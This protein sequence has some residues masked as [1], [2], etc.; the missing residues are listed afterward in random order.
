MKKQVDKGRLDSLKFDTS[1]VDSSGRLFSQRLNI[2]DQDTILNKAESICLNKLDI[3]ALKDYYIGQKINYHKDY[4]SGLEAPAVFFGKSIDYRES[5]K[6][7]DIKYIW[8][9]NRHLF[10]VTLALA[11]RIANTRKYLRK[12]EGYLADWLE[13]NKF[14]RGVNWTSSLEHGIRLINWTFCWHLLEK[15]VDSGLK[16]KWL[17]S[18][19]QHCWFISNNMSAFSSANNHLIGEAA[20]LYVASTALPKFK[21]SSM[22]QKKAYKILISECDKQNYPDGV[23]KE[24]AISYQ[25]FVLDFLLIAALVGKANGNPFPQK[26]LLRLE[27]MIE[28]LAALEDCEG[29][30]PQLG[31]EDD[32]FVID[33]GQREQGVYSSLINSGA[34]L[35]NR[36][37]F[38]KAGRPM[39]DKTSTL[40]NI[41][42]INIEAQPQREWSIPLSFDG[43][44]YYILGAHFGERREQKLVFDCGPLGYL[45]L[46]A[47]GHADALSFCFSAGGCPIFIDPGTY[48]YHA[49]TKWRNYFR[50]TVAH[51]TVCIDSADQSIIAGNFMWSKKAKAS[52]L[53]YEEGIRVKGTHDGY[54]RLHDSVKHTREIIF[55]K[56]SGIW[57]IID[58]IECEEDHKVAL[59][60]HLHPQCKLQILGN[61]A[62]IYFNK[63]SC[64]L[65]FPEDLTLLVY[66]GEEDPALGWYSPSYD[67]KLKT[68]TLKLTKRI[69]GSK[70]IITKFKVR[71]N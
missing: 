47:H 62:E 51:N 55:N 38:I 18:I 4:K 9:P 57:E 11:Y 48:A 43:G 15:D 58:D 36:K 46:A 2:K 37:D 54:M 40:L 44:G 42:D 1:I 31:D 41:A 16:E 22:W 12:F 68:K 67:I 23:N 19:Y 17:E 29:N 56:D 6:I 8:E 21:N 32:G 45:S 71:F 50:S 39:D 69:Q 52:L 33:I 64:D 10:L 27:K 26:Y 7:G 14:L 28:Y 20:G 63:G 24:Q 13:Q 61:K 59:H 5:E 35:F 53:E 60:F 49:N 30:L 34:Y 66:E 25:Q 65:I 70:K 3:F